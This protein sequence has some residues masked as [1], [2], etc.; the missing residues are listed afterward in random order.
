MVGAC[1]KA[2]VRKRSGNAWLAGGLLEGGKIGAPRK[3][4]CTTAERRELC[5]VTC[6][7]MA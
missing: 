4:E 7:A 6:E 2:K 1:A 3:E 5:G